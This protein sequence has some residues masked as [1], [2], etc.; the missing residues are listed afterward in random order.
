VL[1]FYDIATGGHPLY[2]DNVAVS[3]WIDLRAAGKTGLPGRFIELGGYYDLPLTN[4]VFVQ[5]LAQ[6][7]PD[8]CSVTGAARVSPLTPTPNVYYFA[9]VPTCASVAPR[10]IDFRDVLPPTAEQVRIAVGVVNYCRYYGNCTHVTNSTPWFDDIRFGVTTTNTIQSLVDAAAPGDTVIVGA[11]T[12]TGNGYRNITFHGK[13]IVLLATAGPEHTIIDCQG[14]ARG[15]V[16]DSGEDSTLVIDGFTVRNGRAPTTTE[17]PYIDDGGA[18]LVSGE[19]HPTFRNC[20][21]ESS[22]ADAGGGV[23]VASQCGI[24]LEGCTLEADSTRSYDS[25]AGLHS[26]SGTTV[27]ITNCEV[28]DNGLGCGLRTRG[29]AQVDSSAIHDNHGFG[30]LLWGSSR[31][32]DCTI[33]DNWGGGIEGASLVQRC[34]ISRNGGD[35]ISSSGTIESCTI[36]ANHGTGVDGGGVIRDCLIADNGG[37]GVYDRAGGEI[38][39]CLISGNVGGGVVLGGGV[40]DSCTVVGNGN[41]RLDSGGGVHAV[42]GF[43]FLGEGPWTPSEVSAGVRIVSSATSGAADAY[44]GEPLIRDCVI[45]GNTAAH[46]GGIAFSW[47]QI[48]PNYGQLIRSTVSG[49]RATTGGGLALQY[50]YQLR[51]EASVIWGNCADDSGDEIHTQNDSTSVT[52]LCSAVDSAGFAGPGRFV[53]SGPQ[54]FTNPLFCAPASCYSAPTTAGDYHLASGSPCLPESSPCDSLIG[55]LGMGCST[56]GVPDD[57]PPMPLTASLRAFPNPFRADVTFVVGVPAGATGAVE[58]FDVRGRRVRAFEARAGETALR[59]DGHSEQGISLPQ[60]IYFV[61][62]RA[63][64]EIKTQRVILIR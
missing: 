32:S 38:Y 36:T 22:L 35:G 20:R 7:Y 61:R 15:F 12:Y 10:R 56:T 13:E 5:T 9:G 41:P 1:A 45:T 29:A 48:M 21:L 44:Y 50:D 30:M 64:V 16:I 62:L 28:R 46:G 49:N 27:R 6:W 60:G 53:Y 51:V 8:T 23:Y 42:P 40:L 52:F 4:Y 59:W 57:R 34:L 47:D 31:V 11:G 55:A 58:I 54:V 37:R 33:V 18:V 26:E 63:G 39:N 43:Y 25:G 3:P 17:Y 2:Q 24:L 14:A 19:A